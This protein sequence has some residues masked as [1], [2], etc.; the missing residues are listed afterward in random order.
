MVERNYNEDDKKAAREAEA[1]AWTKKNLRTKTPRKKSD[2]L[3]VRGSQFWKV[4]E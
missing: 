2:I 4:K 1:L 3:G